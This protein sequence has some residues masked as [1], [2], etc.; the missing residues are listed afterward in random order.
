MS[1]VHYILRRSRMGRFNF[2]LISEAGRIT[3]SVVVSMAGKT[4]ADLE[5]DARVQ[6]R[7]LAEIF[8][9][10]VSPNAPEADDHLR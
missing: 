6:V 10:T 9:G 5:R 3:G 8:A 4:G 2:T 7:H 1:K